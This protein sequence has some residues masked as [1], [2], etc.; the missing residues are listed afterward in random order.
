MREKRLI[1]VSIRTSNASTESLA[2]QLEDQL[3][4]VCHL[5]QSFVETEAVPT[6]PPKEFSFRDVKRRQSYRQRH[7][8]STS[9]SASVRPTV[10]S[11][12][13][14]QPRARPTS[15]SATSPVPVPV[16]VPG[17][18]FLTIFRG[19]G[20]K[21]TINEEGPTVAHFESVPDNHEEKRREQI[22][23]R[24]DSEP[25]NISET[26]KN[27]VIH[28]EDMTD[29]REVVNV[30]KSAN[31]EPEISNLYADEPLTP[32]HDE[33]QEIDKYSRRKQKQKE[34]SPTIARQAE[35]TPPQTS[36]SPTQISPLTTTS[37]HSY[38]HPEPSNRRVP[39]GGGEIFRTPQACYIIN[40]TGRHLFQPYV[41]PQ[42]LGNL[43]TSEYAK[44]LGLPIKRH[45]RET[46]TYRD[47]E[48]ESV[49]RVS[50]NWSTRSTSTLVEPGSIECTVCE[51]LEYPL[52]FGPWFVKAQR[53]M[54][55]EEER[56][57]QD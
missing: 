11:S 47:T 42:L 44:K 18:S 27:S 55:R 6:R 37:S 7:A 52:I 28:E 23:Q 2:S 48:I 41:D 43:I 40:K 38:H 35:P 1:S 57:V 53:H 24:P 21:D 31:D 51:T 3:R 22:R 9:R 33:Q 50:L 39:S 15:I 4:A 16:P 20:S 5:G 29:N 12:A 10:I 30:D 34:T 49:G 36:T 25:L 8:A 26:S 17:P 32:T 19:E 56:E 45:P 54:S 46:K 13:S 14:H